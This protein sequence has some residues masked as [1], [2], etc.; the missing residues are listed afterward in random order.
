MGG[1]QGVTID[2][3]GT[4]IHHKQLPS[5]KK[6]SRRNPCSQSHIRKHLILKRNTK[7]SIHIKW[8]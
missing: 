1:R 3:L 5:T 4:P 6:S 7:I 2:L 8:T